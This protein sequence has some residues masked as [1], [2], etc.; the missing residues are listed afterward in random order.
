MGSREPIDDYSYWLLEVERKLKEVNKLL[1]ENNPQGV[2]TLL[3]SI[4]H[5][6]GHLASW[7]GRKM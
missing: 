7:V 1:L 6:I 3:Q 4:T 2:I 5:D